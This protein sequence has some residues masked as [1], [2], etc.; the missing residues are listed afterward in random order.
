MWGRE[1]FKKRYSYSIEYSPYCIESTTTRNKFSQ[2][3]WITQETASQK[4]SIQP[5]AETRFKALVRLN[6]LGR[7]D[8]L[9]IKS[10]PLMG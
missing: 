1:P 10:M 8:T 4:G 9:Q 6:C 5:N 3:E 7:T 2:R